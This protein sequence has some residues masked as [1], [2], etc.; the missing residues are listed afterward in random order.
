LI[1]K[2]FHMHCRTQKSLK[3]ANPNC[4]IKPH[5][6]TFTGPKL[7]P[8]S[9]AR[10]F[11]FSSASRFIFSFICEYF[12]KTLAFPLS[13]QPIRPLHRQRLNE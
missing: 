7:G 6:F 4:A 9:L 11:N 12:L 5:Q 3:R 8:V 13:Q 10:R 2:H 1:L